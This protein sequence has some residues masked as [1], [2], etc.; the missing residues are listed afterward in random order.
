M[1]ILQ[2]LNYYERRKGEISDISRAQSQ[3]RHLRRFA[4]VRAER[5]L[6]ANILWVLSRLEI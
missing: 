3:F 1:W 4:K 2:E 5:N 6:K